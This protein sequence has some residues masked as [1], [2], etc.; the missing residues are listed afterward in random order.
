MT[1]RKILAV[2]INSLPI[3]TA[4]LSHRAR[5]RTLLRRRQKSSVWRRLRSVCSHSRSPL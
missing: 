3:K 5:P 2:L 1:G 4:T